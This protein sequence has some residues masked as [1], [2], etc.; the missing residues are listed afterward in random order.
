M[1]A[2]EIISDCRFEL[3]EP[4]QGF[5]TDAELLNQIN[6]AQQAFVEETRILESEAT[7][8]TEA[9]R[10][11]YV[12]PDDWLSTKAVFYNRDAPAVSPDV[13]G[14]KRLEASS[15]EKTG[16]Q[17]PNFLTTDPAQWGEPDQYFVWNHSMY[18]VRTPKEDGHNIRVY[19]KAKPALVTDVASSIAIDDSLAGAIRAFV[20]WKAWTK[21][22]EFELAKD[23]E[24]RYLKFVQKGRRYTK[25]QAGDRVNSVDV[26]T[27]YLYT[28]GVGTTRSGAW[29]DQ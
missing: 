7:M 24:D 1:L 13:K 16:Q 11:S 10:N 4:I 8:D 22:K 17:S 28:R 23:Q 14:W 20:L 15:I 3:L 29:L 2:S 19:Y 18:L 21:E 27:P 25:L 6:K 5:W 26:S 9:G 12:L